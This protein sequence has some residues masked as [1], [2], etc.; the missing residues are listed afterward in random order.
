MTLFS[1]F[2]SFPFKGQYAGC[3]Q[4]SLREGRMIDKAYVNGKE[5]LTGG[6]KTAITAPQKVNRNILGVYVYTLVAVYYACVSETLRL[7]PRGCH[8]LWAPSPK[9][10]EN[11]VHWQGICRH[12]LPISS[13]TTQGTN[14]NEHA[15]FAGKAN[16]SHWDAQAVRGECLVTVLVLQA[17]RPEF[18][19]QSP[20]E[21]GKRELPTP[22]NCPLTSTHTPRR[23][24]MC[25]H[26]LILIISKNVKR[27]QAS[28]FCFPRHPFRMIY[29]S[30]GS[31]F[32]Q[33]RFLLLSRWQMYFNI[34]LS[35]PVQSGHQILLV[36]FLYWTY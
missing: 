14:A 13:S 31:Q 27:R 26:T 18:K 10:L 22:S 7:P 32:K 23:A 34:S 8:T 19:P 3:S 24:H 29:E 33:C 12:T 21:G 35:I 1:N 20:R 6:H 25:T 28:V 9:N 15:P 2:A 36:L 11:L 30:C 16:K 5:Q 4:K 17:R